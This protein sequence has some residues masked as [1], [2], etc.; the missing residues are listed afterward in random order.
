MEI[1][2]HGTVS[3]I[4]IKLCFNNWMY[5]DRCPVDIIE[6]DQVFEFI[7]ILYICSNLVELYYIAFL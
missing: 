1:V 4:F 7:A 3:F 6:V 5:M 2:D